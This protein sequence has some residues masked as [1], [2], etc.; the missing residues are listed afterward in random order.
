M[1]PGREFL[2]G[3][4]GLAYQVEQ[5]VFQVVQAG[6]LV[7]QALAEC[8]GCGLSCGDG[9]GEV[10]FDLGALFGCDGERGIV[11]FNG[12]FDFGEREAG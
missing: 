4:A 6:E 5:L 10:L 7:S 11:G 9:F 3:P 12:R 8:F 2:G 1:H